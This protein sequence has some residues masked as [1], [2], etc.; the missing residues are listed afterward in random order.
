MVVVSVDKIVEL[1]VTIGGAEEV[2]VE[3][4]SCGAGGA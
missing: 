2:D 1:V 3:V 4:V